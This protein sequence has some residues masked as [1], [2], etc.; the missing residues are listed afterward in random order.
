VVCGSYAGWSRQFAVDALP[1]GCAVKEVRYGPAASPADRLVQLGR[2]FGGRM[3]I[4]AGAPTTQAAILANSDA[5][6]GLRRAALRTGADLYVAHYTAALP[7]AADAARARNALYAFDAEDFHTG[8]IPDLAEYAR[9]R[10]I[11]RSIEKAL[12]PGCAHVTAASPGI[13]EA[14]AA[15]YGLRQPT[16]VLNVFPRSNA[17]E[18]PTSKGNA[19]PGPSL[20]WF[21][22]TIG[23][24]RGLECAIQALGLAQTR[25]H[26]YLR[27]TPA[28]GY[29]ASLRQ[30]AGAAGVEDRLHVLE[31]AAPH[32][33]ERLAA[34]HD[35]GF[36]GE[37]GYTFNRRI[38]LTNKQF[39]YLLAG[40][41]AILSD[42][43]AHQAFARDADG[44]V[45]LYETGDAPSLATQLD[46]IL[47]HPDRLAAMRVRAFQLGQERFNWQVEQAKL[48]ACVEQTLR[49]AAPGAER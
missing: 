11:V 12:L 44:A 37:T 15:E 29:G 49:G 14:Y 4:A 6:P 13:A 17:P 21:S 23:P 28:A 38:A 8:E 47:A 10:S 35:L 9:E 36:V 39:S 18:A 41:P 5:T 32:Q 22:Q 30:L 34:Q 27:G 20:Y 1:P 7:A 16:V 46:G 42:V 26:L 31:P 3:L 2:R 45:T 19:E 40:I 24:N 48:I 33:M 43:P 25:P